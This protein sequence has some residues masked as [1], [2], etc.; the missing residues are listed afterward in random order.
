MSQ[1]QQLSL[2]PLEPTIKAWV[3]YEPKRQ[4]RWQIK[5]P[6]EF[7]IQDWVTAST[8]RPKINFVGG[9]PEYEEI[10]I[11]FRDPID[12][13]TTQKLW[14]LFIGLSDANTDD[15]VHPNFSEDW[16]NVLNQFK[17][18]FD[19]KLEM[20]G[21]VGDVVESWDIV[22]CKITRMDFGPLD[23]SND[24]LAECTMWVRPK[25]IALNY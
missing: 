5:M 17:N 9:R 1:Y 22:G 18:G 2:F 23:Y 3:A 11:T 12:P 7:G 8:H 16:K 15:V 6:V 21:P 19:Y 20:L 24:K 4:N 13:S 10:P 14:R 25:V